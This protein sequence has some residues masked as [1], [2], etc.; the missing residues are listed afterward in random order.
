M[1]F[2]DQWRLLV[3]NGMGLAA[4]RAAARLDCLRSAQRGMVPLSTVET[5]ITSALQLLHSKGAPG[6]VLDHL[7][8]TL[9]A[10]P[11]TECQCVVIE[12]VPRTRDYYV[13]THP[14]FM[15][16]VKVPS[17]DN[18]NAMTGVALVRT[19]FKTSVVQG[20]TLR[21]VGD[22]RSLTDTARWIRRTIYSAEL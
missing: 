22:V 9:K 21:V 6:G 13:N 5:T 1:R 11:D 19:P 18:A 2:T 10:W 14:G 20:P 4:A 16:R 15:A 8:P 7:Q 17:L 3:R 12:Y